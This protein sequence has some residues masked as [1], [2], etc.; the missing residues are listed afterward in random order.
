MIEHGTAGGYR[1]HKCR[2]Q[3]CTEAHR[4][5]HT[6][7]IERLR[8]KVAAGEVEIPHG[9]QNAYANYGCRCV[10]CTGAHAASKTQTQRRRAKK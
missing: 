6:A 2:C 8:A 10:P 9:T 1:N 5:A 7:S 4:I 3:P